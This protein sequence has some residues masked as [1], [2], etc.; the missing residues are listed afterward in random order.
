MKRLIL[1]SGSP[2]RKELLGKI[3][4]KFDIIPSNYDEK[5]S[6]D[7]FSYEKIEN[8]ALN[9]GLDVVKNVK[10]NA[11]VISADTVVVLD[12]KIYLSSKLLLINILLKNNFC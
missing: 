2:R 10:D 6:D 8:L 3:G 4:L 1:A 9:K 11:I 7:N 12:N 5:L